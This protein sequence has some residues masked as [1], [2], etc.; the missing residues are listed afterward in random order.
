MKRSVE[1]KHRKQPLQTDTAYVGTSL[2][3]GFGGKISPDPNWITEKWVGHFHELRRNGSSLIV[4]FG[5]KSGS[6]P[7][8][9]T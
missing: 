3:S 1:N 9:T 7:N 4:G 2:V 6:D 8:W 5:E